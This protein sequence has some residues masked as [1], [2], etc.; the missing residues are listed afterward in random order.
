MSEFLDK[1]KNV[2]NFNTY[3]KMK[4]I[5]MFAYSVEIKLDDLD[6]LEEIKNPDGSLSFY[7]EYLL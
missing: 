7:S 3:L 4:T 1:L 2:E 6:G 5:I